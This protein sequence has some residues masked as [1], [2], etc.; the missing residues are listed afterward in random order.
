EVKE[1]VKKDEK[2]DEKCCEEKEKCCFCPRGME[3]I[4]AGAWKACPIDPKTCGD[5]EGGLNKVDMRWVWDK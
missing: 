3:P 4:S 2:K 1:E 5:C